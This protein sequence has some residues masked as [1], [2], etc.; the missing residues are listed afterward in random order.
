MTQSNLVEHF[1]SFDAWR[2]SNRLAILD[3]IA[4]LNEQ[5]GHAKLS[6]RVGIDSGTAVIGK[7][8]G[9]E[10]DVFGDAPNIAARVQAT[11]ESG[12]VVI[13][14]ATHRLMPGVLVVED[15]GARALTG[16]EEPLQLYR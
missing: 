4:R 10:A 13:T 2:L 7:G 16:V 6:A 1:S 12:T 8:V 5:L 14:A 11:A 15:L 3:A 9:N